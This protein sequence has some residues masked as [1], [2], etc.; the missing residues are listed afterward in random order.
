MYDDFIG[1]LLETLVRRF[2]LAPENAGKLLGL[3]AHLVLDEQRGGWT[4][5][6]Q[7]LRRQ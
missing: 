1:R 5:F 7:H 3:L 6:V 4:G 2:G